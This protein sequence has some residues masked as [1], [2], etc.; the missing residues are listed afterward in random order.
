M[1]S[2]NNMSKEQFHQAKQLVKE[3]ERI[4]GKIPPKNISVNNAYSAKYELGLF[5]NKF[6]HHVKQF[7]LHPMT[8]QLG[9]TAGDLYEW[10]KRKSPLASV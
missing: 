5:M 6:D 10:L 7:G 3:L 4:T 8:Q 2:M 1:G 9:D